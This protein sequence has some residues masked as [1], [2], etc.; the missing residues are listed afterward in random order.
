MTG[1]LACVLAGLGLYLYSIELPRIEQAQHQEIEEQRLLPFDYRTVNDLTMITGGES[2]QMERL[3][4][5]R[6]VITAPIHTK[7]DAREIGGLL[8]ALE[9]GRITRIIQQDSTE[10][11]RYGLANPRVS[12]TV[13]LP[14]FEEQLDLGDVEPISSTLYARR[15]SDQQILLTTLS[16]QDFRQKTMS[17][18]RHKDVLFF[19]RQQVVELAIASSGEKPMTLHRTPSIHGLTGNWE[20]SS[21]VQGPADKTAV[22]LLLMTLE[23]LQAQGF[24]DAPDE[25]SRLRQR[26]GPPLR[27]I[28]L[29]TEKGLH[30]L[31]LFQPS[32]Q[33]T[34][35]RD[36]HTDRTY[37]TIKSSI[38]SAIPRDVLISRTVDSLG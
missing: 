19:D 31:S 20:F 1:L 4:G 8:R 30:H 32:D 25:K 6:W 5:G 15:G 18:F 38:F 10:A 3:S 29:Q 26:L 36:Y 12:I 35:L 11:D 23:D 33:G 27:E 9:L 24:I 37:F 28:H 2:V 16:V 13:K 14:D 7:G 22:G 34:N 21:P 17:S